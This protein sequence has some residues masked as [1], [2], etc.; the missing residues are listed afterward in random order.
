MGWKC[1]QTKSFDVCAVLMGPLSIFSGICLPVV[2]VECIVVLVIFF[3]PGKDLTTHVSWARWV[4]TTFK[5][6]RTTCSHEN[7]QG[8][9]NHAP[10][11]G[12]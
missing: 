7:N 6:Q 5:L 10:S 4:G 12:A 3:W 11:K 1:R 2:K 9:K 8:Q